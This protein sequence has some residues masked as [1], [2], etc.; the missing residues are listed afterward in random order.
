MAYQKYVT[1]SYDDGP[2]HDRRFVRMLNDFGIKCTFNLNTASMPENDPDDWHISRAEAAELYR[3]HEIA[4]HSHTHPH[5][6]TMDTEAVRQEI[7]LNR[8]KLESIAGYPV[9]GHAYPYGTWNDAVVKVLGECGIRYA[10]TTRSTEDFA[11]P[12]NPLLLNPTCHHRDPNVFRLIDEFLAA[13]PEDS[14]LLFYLWGHS[15]E[16]DRNEEYNSWEHIEKVLAALSGKPGIRYVT[17]L[18]FFER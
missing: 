18:E 7:L 2:K 11:V 10:R 9:V 14:D 1:L 8:Q 12:E 16:F 13:E 6:E 17:N 15:F 5:L 4:T 3:G